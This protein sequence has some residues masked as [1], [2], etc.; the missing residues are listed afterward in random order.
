[1]LFSQHT[2][3]VLPAA[4][5]ILVVRNRF[6]GDTVLAIPFLRNL[7]RKFPQAT[8]DVLVESDSGDVL[9]DCPYQNAIL[10][11]MRPQRKQSSVLRTLVNLLATAKWLR[12][13]HY[14]R[15]YV[16]KRSASSA[17]LIWLSGIAHRVGFAS[18]LRSCLF[19]RAV[20][21]RS[22]R[23]EAELFLDLLRGDNIEV[24]DGHNENWVSQATARKVESLLAQ[25][26]TNRPRVFIAPRSTNGLRQWPLQ[27]VAKVIQWLVK[28]RGCEIFF[29]GSSYDVEAHDAIRSLVGPQGAASIHDYSSQLSLR[30]TGALLARMHLSLGVDTGL[31]HMAASFGVPVATLFGPTDP[32]QWSPWKTQSAVIRS[33]TILQPTKRVTWH[34]FFA[35][36][37]QSHRWPVG[38][39]AILDIN[40]EQVLASIAPLLDQ[41]IEEKIA[42]NSTSI[43]HFEPS[44]SA[45][46]SSAIR[47]QTIDL[48]RG[49]YRYQV[50]ASP[51]ATPQSFAAV[52]VESLAEIAS[53][54]AARGD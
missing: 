17:L 26:P 18:E 24:D 39:T 7:R 4:E 48:R 30:E 25:V 38:V 27:R 29:C 21:L 37:T 8:I 43:P 40:V 34:P 14:T 9:A 54:N 16:L 46:K 10:T 51:A 41:A 33:A 49:T 13:R 2:Q 47:I 52:P 23:H 50:F 5:R 22:H 20:P 44:P 36:P 45:Q 3:P 31:Q 28:N 35:N 15:A 11:W 6:I 1:M 53:G 12:S 42:D 32:N 19:T